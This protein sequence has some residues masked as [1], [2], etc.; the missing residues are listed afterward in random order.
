MG[1]GTAAPL[2][3]ADGAP[4]PPVTFQI[5]FGGDIKTSTPI[6]NGYRLCTSR[7]GR[8]TLLLRHDFLGTYMAGSPAA[9]NW[10]VQTELTAI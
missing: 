9:L 1:K 8:Y 6:A 3:L 5:K 7:P 10:P 4:C 2:A